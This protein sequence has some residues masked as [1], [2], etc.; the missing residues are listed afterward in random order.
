[1]KDVAAAASVSVMTVSNVINDR[2]GAVGQNTRSRVERAMAD[3]GYYPNLSARALRSARSDTMAFLLRDDSAASLAD[4]L[5]NLYLTGV[6][7]VLRDRGRSLLIH[8][9]RS[10]S[11][12]EDL[13]RP[14]LQGTV[15]GALVLISGEPELRAWYID[16]LIQLERPFVVFDEI[17]KDSAPLSVRAAQRDG[18]RMLAEYLLDR[19]HRRIAF[20]GARNPWA[21]VEQRRLGYRDALRTAGIEPVLELQLFEAD[22]QPAGGAEMTRSLMALAEPPTAIMCASDLLA[23]GAVQALHELR[24]GVPEDVAVTGFDDFD[25][26]AWVDPALTTVRIPAYAMGRIAAAMVIGEA[27]GQPVE[28]REVILPVELVARASA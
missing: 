2:V 27:D 5:T 23:I 3:L 24:I 19:G 12:P 17:V 7:D 15:D 16:R 6:G 13:L 20:V 9:V 10:D 8:T 4:P 14:V 1:M 18:G 25:F 21:V 11:P 22:W 28:A 26:S